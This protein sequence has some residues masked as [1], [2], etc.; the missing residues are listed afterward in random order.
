MGIN[1]L[2]KN[3]KMGNYISK[4]L[5][6]PEWIRDFSAQAGVPLVNDM[7]VYPEKFGDGFAKVAVIEEGLTYRIVDYTLNADCNFTLERAGQFHLIIYLYQYRNCKNLSLKINDIQIIQNKEGNY[8]TLLMTNS[9]TNQHLTLSRETEVRGLTIQASEDWLI[10]NI[11]N[12]GT[13]NFALLKKQAVFQTLLTPKIQK[14]LNEIFDKNSVT[15]VPVLYTNNR[16]LRLLEMFLENI[17]KFGVSSNSLPNSARDI[18]NILKVEKYLINNFAGGFPSI[19]HLARMSFMSASKL[20]TIFKKAFGMGMYEYYQKNRIHKAKELLASGK[21]SVTEA[22]T[23]IGY[24][25]LSNFSNAFKKE[26]KFLPKD[27]KKIG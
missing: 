8:S 13:S 3:N 25:N 21:C 14:L 5:G 10:K 1:D 19:E 2:S 16:V 23:M 12:H 6:L 7:I 4:R 27:F 11:A 20:K 24:Q 22:G 15:K 26:F 18:Q 17:L 9:L